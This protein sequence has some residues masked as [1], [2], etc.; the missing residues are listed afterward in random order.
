[1]YSTI[2]SHTCNQAEKPVRPSS[3][4][5]WLVH[6]QQDLRVRIWVAGVC[7]HGLVTRSL[8]LQW[9][10]EQTLRKRLDQ[11]V[12]STVHGW[13]HY[14]AMLQPFSYVHQALHGQMHSHPEKM[15]R[16]Q[17]TV[18]L[19]NKRLCADAVTTQNHH[20]NLQSQST[21]NKINCIFGYK[22]CMNLCRER[23]ANL[24]ISIGTFSS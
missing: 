9:R 3:P 12:W 24:C 22:I 20:A 2:L 8:C 13:Q 5:H 10:L 18:F 16:L 4:F 6:H 14:G 1:M 23:I 19:F 17:Q 21:I 7:A 11:L 15:E